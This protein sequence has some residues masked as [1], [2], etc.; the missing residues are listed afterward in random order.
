MG[1]FGDVKALG[2]VQKIKK[3]GCATLSISQITTLLVNMPDAQKKLPKD[4]FEEIYALYK[5]Y[6]KCNTKLLYDM[7]EYTKMALK[8]V[9]SFDKI[10][11]Y[12]LYCGGNE[13]EYAIFMEEIRET[14]ITRENIHEALIRIVEND[15]TYSDGGY[16]K[17][18]YES[19]HKGRTLCKLTYE[20]TKEFA[21][22]L[23]IANKNG[24]EDALQKFDYLVTDWIEKM[25]GSSDYFKYLDEVPFYCGAL[26]ANEIISEEKL[27]ELTSYYRKMMD[28]KMFGTAQN[29]V[30]RE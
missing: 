28:D 29:D 26:C 22:V 1:I 19:A 14:E 10:A 25:N 4:K 30:K 27:R 16:I 24:P 5:E 18:M 8:I 12:E 3:G 13:F 20:D 23:S 15:P 11:P 7:N 9:K 2:A 6:R 21:G 17:Y